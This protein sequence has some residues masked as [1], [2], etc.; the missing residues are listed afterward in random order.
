MPFRS[1]L[2]QPM[3]RCPSIARDS[4]PEAVMNRRRRWPL[5][6]GD[7]IPTRGL[8]SILPDSITVEIRRGQTIGALDIAAARPQLIEMGP[9]LAVTL[10]SPPLVVAN[11]Q[12]MASVGIPSSNGF[13]QEQNRFAIAL[14]DSAPEEMPGGQAYWASGWPS[15]TA[16]VS[17]A[18]PF[19]S[20][21]RAPAS[22]R[23][24]TSANSS[25]P[26]MALA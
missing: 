15:S 3:Q 2:A 25:S 14:A 8:L 7:A 24:R 22:I 1:R 10:N 16:W 26:F 21:R 19:A 18:S 5:L 12:V 4:V 13:P 20:P 11:R 9:F 6:G 23:L 17:S